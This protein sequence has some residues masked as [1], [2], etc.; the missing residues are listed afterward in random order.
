MVRMPGVPNLGDAYTMS[1]IADDV[2]MDMLALAACVV[3]ISN[4]KKLI[5]KD[6]IC[7]LLP[8]MLRRHCYCSA[9]VI[10]LY[11]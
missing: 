8:L 6:T 5:G 7:S 3:A 9:K 11:T 10:V 1:A 2:P 4:F